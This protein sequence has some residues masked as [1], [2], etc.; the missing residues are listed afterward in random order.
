MV[1]SHDDLFAKNFPFSG[2]T[3]AV[4]DV[5]IER[6]IRTGGCLG[7]FFIARNSLRRTS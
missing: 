5:Q 4:L 3:K 1:S 2:G 7:P 6:C